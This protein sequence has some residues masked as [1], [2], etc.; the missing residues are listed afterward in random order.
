MPAPYSKDLRERVVAAY[1]PGAGDQVEVAQRFNVGEATVRR[2]WA[3]KR[4]SGSV[5]PKT[6]VA[7]R[8]YRRALELRRKF[9]EH[10][11]TLNASR[12][13]FIDET[14]ST[15][16]KGGTTPGHRGGSG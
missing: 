10:P 15:V 13:F 12:A 6:P 16:A 8:P 11:P 7:S 1:E 2:W 9:C 14:G 3:L 4:K 5:A